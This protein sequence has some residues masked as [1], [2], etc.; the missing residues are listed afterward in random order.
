MRICG[1]IDWRTLGTLLEPSISQCVEALMYSSVKC[2]NGLTRALFYLKFFRIVLGNLLTTPFA[3]ILRHP[4][5]EE[6]DN[7]MP[8]FCR[9]CA[10]MER[11]AGACRSSAQVCFGSPGSEDPYLARWKARARKPLDTALTPDQT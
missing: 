9:D 7:S 3:Q 1:W 2:E 6:F 8:Q 5:V 4:F 10:E 11:C